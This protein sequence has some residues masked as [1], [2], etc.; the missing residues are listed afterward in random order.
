MSAMKE[1]FGEC[2]W[3]LEKIHGKKVENNKE[4]SPLYKG[5]EKRVIAKAMELSNQTGKSVRKCLT[6]ASEAIAVEEGATDDGKCRDCGSVLIQSED[7]V[8]CE[9]CDDPFQADAANDRLQDK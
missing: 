4:N 3:L 8:Y 6:W 1:V 5:M 9:N 2:Q 7:C